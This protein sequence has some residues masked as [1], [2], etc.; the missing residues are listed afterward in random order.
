M[1][2]QQCDCNNA[3]CFWPAGEY[4]RRRNWKTGGVQFG[5]GVQW[6]RGAQEGGEVD[7]GGCAT[8]RCAIQKGRMAGQGKEYS[9]T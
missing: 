4:S 7:E 2:Q 3:A 6:T 5:L 1:G 9:T 8:L